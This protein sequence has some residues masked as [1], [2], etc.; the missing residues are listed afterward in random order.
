[1]YGTE[2]AAIH[3]D[4]A[5]RN[6]YVDDG[7]FRSIYV[8]DGILRFIFMFRTCVTLA[9]FKLCTCIGNELTGILAELQNVEV[10]CFFYRT[11]RDDALYLKTYLFSY[12]PRE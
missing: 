7:F 8:D 9:F 1:M 6:L 3:V 2:N 11:R 4:R 10:I 5:A 12:Y